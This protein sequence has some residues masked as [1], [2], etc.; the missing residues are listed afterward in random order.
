M[1][2]ALYVLHLTPLEEINNFL[3][4]YFEFEFAK[5]VFANQN[6]LE[7]LKILCDLFTHIITFFKK[8]VF[9]TCSHVPTTKYRATQ[10]V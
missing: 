4:F 5:I 7:C 8:M 9:L 6:T 2:S 10:L 3:W 1:F